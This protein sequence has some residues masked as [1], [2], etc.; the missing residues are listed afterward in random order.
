MKLFSRVSSLVFLLA[1]P[2]WAQE[3]RQTSQTDGRTVVLDI[4][5]LDLNPDQRGE[6]EKIIRDKRTID[7]LTTEGKA[8]P[9]A[10]VQLRA[11]SGGQA[12]ARIGQRIP[13]QTAATSQGPQQI[14]Y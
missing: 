4:D 3:P 12:I 14:Q 5:I 6:I 10:G 8:R 9:V 13:V 11:R 2:A 1:L 7:R